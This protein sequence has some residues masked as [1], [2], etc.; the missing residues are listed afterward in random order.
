MYRVITPETDEQLE[1]YYY[2][3]WR[4][5]REPFQRPLGSEQDEYDQVG[6]HR[7]VVNEAEEPV[8]VGRLHFNSPE[9]AQIRFMA[10]APEYRGK[11]MGSL[12]ST[13]LSL[14]RAKKAQP[15]W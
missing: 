10:V 5:L 11:G 6:H 9:E 1:R 12:L 8:A 2:L 4:V 7:M 14:L 3:R 13:L 15:M